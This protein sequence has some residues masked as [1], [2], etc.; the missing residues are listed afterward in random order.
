MSNHFTK[1]FI[2]AVDIPAHRLVKF[3]SDDNTVTLATAGTDDVIGVSDNVDVKAGNTVDVAT[4][5]VEKVQ[6]GGT[7]V[8]GKSIT[9]GTGGKAVAAQAG[10]NVAG[11]ALCSAVD[12][13]IALAV[14]CRSIIPAAPTQQTQ[15]TG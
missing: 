5:G 12:K 7:V 3:G 10:D 14:M 11:Y 1:T 2:A 6:Y 4:L 15:P 13:D 9:A 8:R